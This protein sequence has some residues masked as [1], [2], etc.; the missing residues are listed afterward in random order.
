MWKNLLFNGIEWLPQILDFCFCCDRL[1]DREWVILTC[2][3]IDHTHTHTNTDQP[4]STKQQSVYLAPVSQCPMCI[5]QAV[6]L[7]RTTHIYTCVCCFYRYHRSS[8]IRSW[9]FDSITERSRGL[10]L[11][12][13]CSSNTHKEKTLQHWS[14]PDG[15]R[16][17]V[18]SVRIYV[19]WFLAIQQV[20]ILT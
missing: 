9:W 14:W 4:V 20:R 15:T 3:Y 10:Q 8:I 5:S 1:C 6:V 11:W 12:E 18:T 19:L 13:T 16:S 2:H 17:N 7:Y